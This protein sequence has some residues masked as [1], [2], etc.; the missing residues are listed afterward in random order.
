MDKGILRSADLSEAVWTKS[1]RSGTSGD[2]ACVEVTPIFVGG[3]RL[4]T[5][6][7]DSTDPS[8]PV[9]FFWNGEYEA[10]VE[11]IRD[12]QEDLLAP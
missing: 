9:L 1:K 7:R 11:A 12:G 2:N 8:G 6:M 5:A 4:G 3:S 10:Y